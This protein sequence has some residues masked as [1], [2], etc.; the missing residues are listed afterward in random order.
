MTKN[1]KQPAR[2]FLRMQAVLFAFALAVP[3][4]AQERPYPQREFVAAFSSLLPDLDAHSA[5]NADEAQ[6]LTALAEGLFAYDPYTLEPV[7]A[8]AESWETSGNGLHWT[9]SIRDD[10]AFEDGTKIT[11]ETL[12]DSWMQLLRRGE[13][14]PYAS[15]LDCVKGAR[16]FRTGVSR[17]EPAVRAPDAKT[18]EVELCTPTAHF[19][20]ILCHHAFTACLP[21][22]GRR[23]DTGA[24]EIFVP[25]SSGPFRVKSAEEHALVLEK[26]PHYWDRGNVALPSLRFL[27]LEDA[28]ES[29][30]LFNQGR[31]HW[32]A[33]GVSVEKLIDYS[34]LYLTPMFSTEYFFFRTTHS[35][36]Q[37]AAVR[38]ALLQAVPW[39]ELRGGY[40]IPASTLIFPVSGYPSPEGILACNPEEAEKTLRDAGIG[41][42]AALDPVV[43]FYPE[44]ALYEE[45]AGILQTAWEA[46]GFRVEKRCVPFSRYYTSLRTEEYSVGVTSWIGDFADPA[47][48]L[49]M[50]RPS[51]NL[52]DSGWNS[53]A[54]EELF[55][56]AAG[57]D[58]TE[59]RYKIFAEAEKLLLDD[60]VILPLSHNPALNVIDTN[61]IQGWYANVLDIHPF[62]SIRF[63]PRRPMPGIAMGG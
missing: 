51:S 13:E 52:N 54:F 39:E 18:L 25:L 27:F 23:L 16:E 6:M 62:K 44:S 49:E 41:E 48:F 21:E 32:L 11:A 36:V 26:N 57:E 1:T 19:T 43:L 63:T 61:G 37:N 58:D 40:L 22:K 14:A 47:A 17:E 35:A 60:A 5:Y 4:A 15:M 46:L 3:L 59:K 28:E 9:F 50:F 20:R 10:A 12:R 7:P 8:L 2:A 24:G 30:A 42:P 38:R 56:Q 55:V 34:T 29:T 31:I 45:K 53:P 33:G